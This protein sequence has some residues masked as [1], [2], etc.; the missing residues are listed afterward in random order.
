MYTTIYMV[1]H[2][3]SPYTEGNERTRGLTADGWQ[4]AQ[5]VTEALRNEGIQAFVSSP[6][7]RAVL[8]I[9][10]LAKQ[11]QLPIET[12]ED[13]RERQFAGE[14]YI[15][16]DEQFIPAIEK[17][18]SDPDYALP[19][20]ETSSDCQNRAI[21]ALKTILTAYK[22]MKVAIGT[23]GNVM[24]LMMQYFDPAYNLAFFNQTRKPDIYKLQF[25]QLE[26]KQ[27]TRIEI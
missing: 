18:F 14:D 15:I 20:G 26:L 24:T 9:E 8:T 27:V 13:L 25:E 2:A 4:K 16:S 23:H 7:A 5:A 17:M 10:G 3:E 19:G 21:A 6:Y 22:G 1:R 11:L 12:I